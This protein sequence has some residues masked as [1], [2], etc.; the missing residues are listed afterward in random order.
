MNLASYKFQQRL[1]H[2]A[3]LKGCHVEIVNEAYTRCA[4]R[5]FCSLRD[6]SQTCGYCGNLK[7]TKEEQIE[8]DAKDCQKKFDRDVNGARNIYIKY[9]N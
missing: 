4:E 3:V 5:T 9:V 1:K 8:C 7:K 6:A 2:K